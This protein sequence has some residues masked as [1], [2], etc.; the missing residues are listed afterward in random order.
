MAL[1]AK[2]DERQV[3]KQAAQCEPAK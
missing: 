1:I 3:D 2:R